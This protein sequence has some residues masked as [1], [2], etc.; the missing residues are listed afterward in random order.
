MGV[1]GVVAARPTPHL[2]RV[3]QAPPRAVE[4]RAIRPQLAAGTKRHKV[5]AQ[6]R[7]PLRVVEA[8][9]AATDTAASAEM[10]AVEPEVATAAKDVVPAEMA[11]AAVVGAARPRR[12][13]V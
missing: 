12:Q 6:A 2:V 11:V 5:R 4:R 9:R 8:P 3:A 1:G 10:A 7:A 13:V